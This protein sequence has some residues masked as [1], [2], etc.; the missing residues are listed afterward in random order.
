MLEGSLVSPA[1]LAFPTALKAERQQHSYSRVRGE[2][3]CGALCSEGPD[4]SVTTPV[5]YWTEGEWS[6]SSVLP[7]LRRKMMDSRSVAVAPRGGKWHEQRFWLANHGCLNPFLTWFSCLE[8]WEEWLFARVKGL[9]T[10]RSMWGESGAGGTGGKREASSLP[11]HHA[12]SGPMPGVGITTSWPV[13]HPWS[14]EGHGATQRQKE[15]EVAGETLVFLSWWGSQADPCLLRFV[16][17]RS[18]FCLIVHWGGKFSRLG[19]R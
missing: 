12:G 11:G 9:K 5:S 16:T 15:W 6:Q 4:P 14:S 10:W 13:E 1:M 3:A 18:V 7:V 17:S 8:S 19:E 2:A